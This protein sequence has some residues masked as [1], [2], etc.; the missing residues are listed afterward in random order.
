MIKVRYGKRFLD[1]VRALPKTQ[2]RKLDVLLERFVQNP[3]NPLLHT[4]KLT[5]PLA[6]FWSFRITRDWRVIFQFFE[7]EIIQ[8]ILAKHRKDIYRS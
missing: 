8:L 2:Q 3:F 1:S 7:P 4:K 6:G 5:G